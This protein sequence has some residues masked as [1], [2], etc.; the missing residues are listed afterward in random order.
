MH[1]LVV[2]AH[3]ASAVQGAQWPALQKRSVPQGLPSVTFPI[4]VQ[5]GLPEVQTT[6]ACWHDPASVQSPP[7]LQASQAP[8]LQTA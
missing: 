8:L 4:D 2:G 6:F 3:P 5:T 7:A 1:G